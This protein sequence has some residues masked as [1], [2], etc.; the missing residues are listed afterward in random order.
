[1]KFFVAPEIRS[2]STGLRAAALTLTSACP[3]GTAGMGTSV[4]AITLSA[5]PNW[6]KVRARIVAVEDE[7]GGAGLGLGGAVPG[8]LVPASAPTAGGASSG[9]F[10][11]GYLPRRVE[12]PRCAT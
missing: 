2:R 8:V 6:S 1:M 4:S 11:A 10:H 3:A 5:G 12:G 9:G 7:G